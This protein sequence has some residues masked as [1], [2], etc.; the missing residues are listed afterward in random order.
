[1]F[2][3]G[4]YTAHRAQRP[5]AIDASGVTALCPS[6]LFVRPAHD[7]RADLRQTCPCSRFV[8]RMRT[9]KYSPT[10]AASASSH[11]TAIMPTSYIGPVYPLSRAQ[12]TSRRLG[13]RTHVFTAEIRMIVDSPARSRLLRLAAPTGGVAP[14]RSRDK[15]PCRYRSCRASTRRSPPRCRS[16]D[17]VVLVGMSRTRQRHRPAHREPPAITPT[18]RMILP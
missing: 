2:S 7:L 14:L 11:R 18:W 9:A 1:M 6:V 5:R 10:Q 8:A 12:P 4:N 13:V 3:S 17:A 16:R 15:V